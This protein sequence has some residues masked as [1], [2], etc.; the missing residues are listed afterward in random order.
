MKEL[1]RNYTK[2]NIWA[3]ERICEVLGKLDPAL[4]D[5]ELTSSLKTLRKTIYH[6][7]DAETIWHKRLNGKSLSGW[8][9]ESF[10]GDFAEFQT[11]FLGVSGNFFM[12][13]LNKDKTQLKQELTYKNM[14]GKKF[15]HK[16]TNIILHCINHSTFHRG[17][18]ITM[19]RN[20]GVTELPSTD[21]IA[22]L[23]E[24]ESK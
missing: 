3:N 15:T 11:Q 9:S 10:K 16:I 17:Q 18:I 21:Y 12:Y 24:T 19:L 23:R 13:V 8:P 22:F 2:Y 4:L 20:L 14:E 5:K 1:L 7:W 6:I